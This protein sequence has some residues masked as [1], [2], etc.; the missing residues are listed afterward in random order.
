MAVQV[1]DVELLGLEGGDVVKRG[2]AVRRSRHLLTKRIEYEQRP[3]P[4]PGRARSGCAP[5]RPG[6]K[7]ALEDVGFVVCIDGFGDV[8]SA[9]SEG[10]ADV[11]PKLLSLTQTRTSDGA[12]AAAA[13]VP[14]VDNGSGNLKGWP[15]GEWEMISDVV[16]VRSAGR[17]AVRDWNLLG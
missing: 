12:F 2:L 11:Q 15:D 13:V 8:E 7:P 6:R 4:V 16:D 3:C 5:S 17:G 14:A 9:T 10:E 1:G